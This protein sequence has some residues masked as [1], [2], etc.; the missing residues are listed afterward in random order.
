MNVSYSRPIPKKDGVGVKGKI[1]ITHTALPLASF[2]RSHV[3]ENPSYTAL[4]TTWGLRTQ[5]DLFNGFPVKDISV[6]Y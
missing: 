1:H 2:A 5:K 4:K 6:V 3:A